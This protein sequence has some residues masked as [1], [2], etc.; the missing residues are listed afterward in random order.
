MTDPL[1]A[2]PS[3]HS[4][5]GGPLVQWNFLQLKKSNKKST[6]V[7]CFLQSSTQIGSKILIYGGCNYHGDPLNQLFLYDTITY[8]W[9][10]PN[11][12]TE[13]HDDSPG[14]RYGHRSSSPSTPSDDAP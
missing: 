13:Y 3:P 5:S 9:N 4:S 10:L 1:A 11:H 8:Q 14:I 12:I 7:P 6:P 2:S